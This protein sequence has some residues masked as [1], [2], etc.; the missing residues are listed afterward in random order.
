MYY[1]V[2]ADGEDIA[3]V[4]ADGPAE[5]E[6]A[7]DAGGELTVR[8]ATKQEAFTYLVDEVGLSHR[9]LGTELDTSKDYIGKRLRGTRDVR[10]LDVLAMERLRQ[11]RDDQK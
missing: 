11:L 1:V 5:A 7:L 8:Q 2:S 9:K 10:R 6:A 4:E 3:T